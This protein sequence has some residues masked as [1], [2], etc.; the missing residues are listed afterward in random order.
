[1]KKNIRKILLLLITCGLLTGC[2]ATKEDIKN[3][4]NPEKFV[5]EAF[6][7]YYKK[8]VEVIKTE[9]IE[10]NGEITKIIELSLKEDENFT[11]TSCAYW[12]A[13]GITFSRRY[14]TVNNYTG[15][16][17]AKFIKESLGTEF[18]TVK[19]EARPVQYDISCTL[20]TEDVILELKDISLLDN[21]LNKLVEMSQ[22]KEI[23]AINL[24]IQYLDKAVSLT[25]N[26]STTKE[27]INKKL[28]ELK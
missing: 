20:E 15:K 17:N 28:S 27:D 9:D 4:E 21:L 13:D 23:Y 25:I 1:M 16:Y 6:Q 8:E 19:T 5:K 12:E 2:G 24:K 18:G 3:S 26:N 14:T 10:T 7:E 22:E 11:F